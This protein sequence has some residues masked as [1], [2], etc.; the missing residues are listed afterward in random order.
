M[1]TRA[2]SGRQQRSVARLAAVQAL[3][4]MEASGA[5][6]EAVVREF[7]DHRFGGDIEGV[8]MA[9]AD[10]PFFGDLVRGMVEAQGDVD[11]IIAK[12]LA[13]GWRLERID[14]TVRAILRAGA[15]ELTRR[16]DVPVEVAI[17]E[18]VEIAKSFF[19]GPEPG[20]VNA[21][22]DAIARERRGPADERK[23]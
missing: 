7:S 10:E 13:T 5:G 3:Y 8:Q 18:Y 16:E 21:T 1:T 15:Y 12:R 2:L 4:Q 17:D 14:A 22:L 6:V 11:Q 23:G 20:F 19:E 9:E